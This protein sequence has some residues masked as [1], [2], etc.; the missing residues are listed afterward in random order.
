MYDLKL[1]FQNLKI[2][3]EGGRAR[4]LWQSFLWEQVRISDELRGNEIT[5]NLLPKEHKIMLHKYVPGICYVCLVSFPAGL[6]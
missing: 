2:T 6:F 5:Y 3:F 1:Q 4:I